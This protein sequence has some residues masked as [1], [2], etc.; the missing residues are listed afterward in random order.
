[1][2]SGRRPPDTQEADVLRQILDS[3]RRVRHGYVQVVLQDGKVMQIE[4][5][6]KR[7]LGG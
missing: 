3:I 6:E 4:T 2:T 1:M 5:M 7:R